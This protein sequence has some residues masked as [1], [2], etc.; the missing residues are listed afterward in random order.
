MPD[1]TNTILLAG[2]GV[3]GVW[4]LT[5]DSIRETTREIAGGTVEGV[6]GAVEGAGTALFEVGTKIGEPIAEA[7]VGGAP[8]DA[9]LEG[10]ILGES[11]NVVL[12][13]DPVSKVSPHRR[14]IVDDGLKLH[15]ARGAGDPA[16]KAMQ[17]GDT[18]ILGSGHRAATIE[19]L[20]AAWSK[21]AEAGFLP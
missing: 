4:L 13:T 18:G 9:E 11:V 20:E 12:E 15:R 5:R 14:Q 19:Q 6:A 3:A 8:A 17:A 21:L 10:W 7:V 16:I 2:L 1:T